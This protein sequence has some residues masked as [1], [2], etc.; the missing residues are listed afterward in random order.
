MKKEKT[1]KP[2]YK[3][4][5][6]WIIVI[7]VVAAVG[8]GAGDS[9]EKKSGNNVDVNSEKKQEVKVEEQVIYDKNDIKVTV[10]GYKTD[11]FFGDAL[12]L[13]IENNSSKNIG[14]STG[15]SVAINGIMI[16]DLFAI[17]VASGKKTNE[18]LTFLSTDLKAAGIETI[19]D[20]EFK[21]HIY[22]NESYDTIDDSDLITV[23]TN[24]DKDFKQK[25]DESGTLAVDE[26]GVKIFVKKVDSEDSFWG[27]DIYLLVEN[28]TGKNISVYVEDVSVNGFMAEPIYAST[29]RKDKVAFDSITFLDTDL[30][31]QGI[32]KIENIELSF[33]VVDDKSYSTILKTEPVKIDI[34]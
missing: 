17:D 18:E 33:K 12:Q 25:I 3:R 34:K 19:K 4:I 11:G 30:E 31:E 27:A 20:I 32:T 28:N 14:M 13:M 29:I 5:W 10:T 7:I 8:S 6:L 16:G 24:A 21:L 1:K 26:K 22:D 2:I 15:D 9:D 23:T